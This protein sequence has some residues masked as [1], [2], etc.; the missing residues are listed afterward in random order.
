MSDAPKKTLSAGALV[1]IIL[2][3]LLGVLAVLVRG[4]RNVKLTVRLKLKRDGR[5]KKR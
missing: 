2:A 1:G 3:T 4:L 5:A